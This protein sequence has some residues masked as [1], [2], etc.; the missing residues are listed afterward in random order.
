MIRERI[1]MRSEELQVFRKG[2]TK[3]LRGVFV[4]RKIVTIPYARASGGYSYNSRH[5]QRGIKC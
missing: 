1:N 3:Q 4:D 5:S 2:K